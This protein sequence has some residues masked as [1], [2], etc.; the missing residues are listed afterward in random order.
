MNGKEKSGIF[1]AAFF[2]KWGGGGICP[3]AANARHTGVLVNN[4]P[5]ALFLLV[6][7]FIVP[8]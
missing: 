8:V 4:T 7:V 6:S 5:K 2:M 3:Y 1:Y